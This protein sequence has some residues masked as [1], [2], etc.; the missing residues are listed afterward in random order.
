MHISDTSD[1]MRKSGL[2]V[3]LK[4]YTSSAQAAISVS[5][6]DLSGKIT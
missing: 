6:S 2:F 3:S 5:D 4:Q 1:L